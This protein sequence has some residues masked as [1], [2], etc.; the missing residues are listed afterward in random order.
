MTRWR[1]TRHNSPTHWRQS[2]VCISTRRLTATSNAPSR[3]ARWCASPTSKRIARAARFGAC[4]RHPQHLVGGVDGRHA[5]AG[6]GE[7]QRGARRCRC[8]RR[9]TSPAV[10]R[11]AELRQDARLR[12]GQQLTD[13]PAE[14]RAVERVGHRGIGVDRVAVVIAPGPRGRLGHA[15]LPES[16]ALSSP[17]RSGVDRLTR[18][19]QV[20]LVAVLRGRQLRRRVADRAPRP[21]DRRSRAGCPP[22]NAPGVGLGQDRDAVVEHLRVCEQS[23][24]D[25]D[26]AGAEILVDLE[27]RVRAAASRRHEHVRRRQQVRESRSPGARR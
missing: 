3:C 26:A 9:S 25:D 15:A 13:R 12:L 23:R 5:R 4:P 21:P 10:E 2:G 22:A 20:G 17:P 14:P 8:P 6:A 11:S 18:A 24:R 7:D 27:R 19:R 1:L 16:V